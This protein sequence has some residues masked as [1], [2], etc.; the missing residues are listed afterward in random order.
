MG[1][2]FLPRFNEGAL[3][4]AAMAP[5]GVSME[6]SNR[7]ALRIERMLMEIPE[8]KHVSRRT[9]RAELDEHAENVNFSEIDVGLIQPDRPKP[10][11]PLRHPASDPRAAP[12]RRGQGR[13]AA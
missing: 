1:G 7:I 4:I 11:I 2:E 10:G 5:P 9:G 12:V 3:T 13:P 6:E 8:V